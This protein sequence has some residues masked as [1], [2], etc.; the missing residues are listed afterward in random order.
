MT[1]PL[2]PAEEAAMPPRRSPRTAEDGRPITEGRGDGRH[3]P[4]NAT[5]GRRNVSSSKRISA[6]TETNHLGEQIGAEKRAT[7][8]AMLAS[9][10]PI[11]ETVTVSAH[12]AA[13]YRHRVKPGLDLRA[14]RGELERLRAMGGISAREPAWLRAA[15][16]APYRVLIGN[17][18]VLPLLAR[19]HC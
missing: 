16:P 15:N 4:G 1:A 10:A 11:A 3:R 5:S 12:A 17:A 8:A 9:P 13:R 6:R 2:H 7:V 19:A 18:I 14:A